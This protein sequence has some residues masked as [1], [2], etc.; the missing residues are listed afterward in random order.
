MANLTHP[1]SQLEIGIARG[2]KGATSTA[3]RNGNDIDRFSMLLDVA[4]VAGTAVFACAFMLHLT[5]VEAWKSIVLHS[6]HLWIPAVLIVA[7]AVSIVF[8]C[9]RLRLY[10][11]ERLTSI[12]QEQRHILQACLTAGLLLAAALCLLHPNDSRT[13]IVLVTV[14]FTTV[15]LSSRRLIS[16]LFLYRS[17]REGAGAR[18]VFIVGT[19]STARALRDNLDNM[20]HLGY[21][22]KGFIEAPGSRSRGGPSSADVVG[23]LDS[24]FDDVRQH[25][26][27]E[28]F[29]A[30]PCDRS[31]VQQVLQ[32]ARNHEVNVRF[33]PDLYDS[34]ILNPTVECLGRVPT[35]LLWSRQVPESRLFMKRV[36]DIAISTVTLA[37]LSPV[38]LIIAIAI[39]SNSHG[40]V[41]YVSDRLGKKGRVFRCLK[42]R[43]MVQ[44]AERLRSAL[45]SK[46]QRDGIL[47]KLDNDPRVTRVGRFLRKYSL[48]ELPQFVNVLRG[49]MSV[50]GPRP[51][52]AEEVVQYKPDHLR[53][54][55]VTPGITGLW[56]VQARKDPSYDKYVSLDLAYIENWSIL[57]DFEIILR[58]IGVVVAGTG[59]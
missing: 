51:P 12:L 3:G 21:A 8:N 37:A 36:L 40:P 14:A 52:L 31:K 34:P 56:Q 58:T 29:F 30:T 32:W 38:F 11:P 26:I 46:N 19:G 45:S 18:N 4:G 41:F 39:K 55:N 54:L 10:T 16:R 23:S 49:D 50:V 53:R 15:L 2:D 17:F 9:E 59:S 42:F 7:Y 57:L 48:D 13:R 24:V 5:S 44:D 43:T 20:R 25:F 33:V 6:H 47:F 27:D 28:I 1:E 35:I 22:F